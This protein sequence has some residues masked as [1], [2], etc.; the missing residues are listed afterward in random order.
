MLAVIF[1]TMPH[2]GQRG[3]DTAEMIIR[4]NRDV[5][6]WQTLWLFLV[7][8]WYNVIIRPTKEKP[9]DKISVLAC[10]EVYRS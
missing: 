8:R 9:H 10:T 1:M 7:Y 2:P 4:K 6:V 5:L 3:P